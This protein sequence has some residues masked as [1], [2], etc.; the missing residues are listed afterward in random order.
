MLT[1][2]GIIIGATEGKYG[3]EA[4]IGICGGKDIVILLKYY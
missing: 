2:G 3:I 4:I 1:L